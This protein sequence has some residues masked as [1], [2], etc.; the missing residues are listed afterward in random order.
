[1]IRRVAGIALLLVSVAA[2][3]NQPRLMTWSAY[4][5]LSP[6]WPYVLELQTA[7]G[8]LLYFGAAHTYEPRDPQAEALERAWVRFRPDLAFTEGAPLAYHSRDEAVARAGEPGL[9]RFLAARDNVPTTSLEPARAE[10]LAALTPH[11]GREKLKLFYILRDTSEFAE[12]SSPALVP[13]EV[14]R[15][16]RIYAETPGLS[17]YPRD[18]AEFEAAYARSL[19]GPTKYENIPRS[20]FDPVQ[21]ASFLNEVSRASGEYRDLNAVN[22]IARHVKS[23]RRVF[24]VMGGSHVVMQERVLRAL[25]R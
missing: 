1:M 13:Q 6:A 12:R 8:A 4:A 2:C 18:L 21:N 17:G 25:L 20:W 3:S 22:R 15:L 19:P 23:G 7:S 9:V 11:F 24:A 16:L 14:E 5:R 10:E